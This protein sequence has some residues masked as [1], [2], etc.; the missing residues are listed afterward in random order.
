MHGA[1]EG[2]N[3]LAVSFSHWASQQSQQIDNDIAKVQKALNDLVGRL[4]HLKHLL[5]GFGVGAA[6]GLAA[7]LAGFGQAPFL[8]FCG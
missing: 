4:G 8:P 6:L 5:I 3:T 7:L 2:F 1:L